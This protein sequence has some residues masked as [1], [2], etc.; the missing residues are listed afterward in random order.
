MLTL[1]EKSFIDNYLSTKNAA[2]SARL[3]GYSVKTARQIGSKLLTN[4]DVRKV[5]DTE[6]EKRVS[7]LNKDTFVD[8]AMVE[9]ETLPKDSPNR[10]RYLALAG[11]G[12]GIIGNGN[13][14]KTTNTLNIQINASGRESAP[15]LWELTR[16]LIGET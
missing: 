13:E 11:Q 2:E 3:A 1:R 9:F 16:K 6:L 12:K 7:E 10:P 4:I 8:K 5:I 15:E 14:S